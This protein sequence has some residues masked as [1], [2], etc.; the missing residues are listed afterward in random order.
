MPV[1]VNIYKGEYNMSFNILPK[2]CQLI[3]YYRFLI[4]FLLFPVTKQAQLSVIVVPVA[5]SLVAVV[6]IVFGIAYYFQNRS[7]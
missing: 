7:R 4:I 6:L 3:H 2:K 5:F 1:T